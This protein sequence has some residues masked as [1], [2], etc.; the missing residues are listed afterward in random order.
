M[1][2]LL[3]DDTPA[4]LCHGGKQVLAEMLYE[5]LRNQGVDVEHAR[6]W[7][8]DQSA[9]VIHSF[10][11]SP[12]MVSMAHQAGARVV[13][14]HIVDEMTSSSRSRRLWHRT[15]NAAIRELAP[16]PVRRLFPWHAFPT[17]DQLVY[18]NEADAE[19]AVKI[20][21]IPRDRAHVIPHGCTS[22]E[23]NRMQAGDRKSASYLVSV[24]SIVP[25]KNS[26][27]LARSA[28]RARVPL[29]F[30]G[31]PF[32]E[33]DPYFKE[34]ESLIDGEFVKY[35]G[36]VSESDKI[37]WMTGA[38]GFVLASLAESGCIAVYE[39]AAAGLPM[40]LSDLPWARMY[41]GGSSIQLVK[42]EE[43]DL[44]AQL[45]PF[46]DLSKRLNGLTFPVATWGDI[47][48]RYLSVYEGA[49]RSR[50]SMVGDSMRSFTDQTDTEPGIHD[51][52]WLQRGSRQGTE[53]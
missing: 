28:R 51:A 9:D 27:V 36:H 38:S 23:I 53:Q 25:R 32:N 1:R 21:G 2:I 3:H 30:L 42:P 46:F 12:A 17:I 52:P 31:K 5:G 43:H 13:L 18:V 26:V 33:D 34:F 45:K 10:G 29:V 11:C 15:R 7:D 37:A 6:W 35:V 49:M 40:L 50:R 16:G 20:Y 22:D 8:P 39:A 19:T 44:A 24:G 48:K 41:G 14:T 47:A 4:Y